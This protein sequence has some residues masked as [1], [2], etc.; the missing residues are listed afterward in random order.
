MYFWLPEYHPRTS[1]EQVTW[2]DLSI[3]E[4]P[5]SKYFYLKFTCKKG[6]RAGVSDDKTRTKS[7]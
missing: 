3:V 7:R 5:E 6:W 1:S 2:F 4:L